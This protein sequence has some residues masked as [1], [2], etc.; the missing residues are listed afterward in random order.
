MEPE[1]NITHATMTC[2]Q[3]VFIIPGVEVWDAS[4]PRSE[5]FQYPAVLVCC[6]ARGYD[7]IRGFPHLARSIADVVCNV[8]VIQTNSKAV[9]EDTNYIDLV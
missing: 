2:M 4:R 6:F 8:G 1:Y 7:V 5:L 9:I 3:A